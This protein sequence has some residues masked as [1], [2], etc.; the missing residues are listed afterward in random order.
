MCFS[1]GRQDCSI[2]EAKQET[3]KE[4]VIEYDKKKLNKTKIH[5]PNLEPSK[6]PKTDNP[7]RHKPNQAANFPRSTPSKYVPNQYPNP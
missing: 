2:S 6:I 7:A 1:S 5:M 3:F 4:S